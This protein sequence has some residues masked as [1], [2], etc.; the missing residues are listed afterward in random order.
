VNEPRA[1]GREGADQ[2]AAGAEESAEQAREAEEAA[3]EAE[4]SAEEAQ[5]AATG[6]LG[7]RLTP[8]EQSE[9]FL[10]DSH[11]LVEEE[12]SFG[13]LGDPLPR[14][15][16]FFIGFFGA[17]GALLA[18]WLGEQILSI[19]S[20][21]IL[22]VVAMFLAVGLNPWVELIMRRGIKRPWAVL[23]VILVVL[24]VLTG[25]LFAIVPVFSDQV[26][27]IVDRAPGWFDQLQH[28]RRIQ[29]LDK[30]YD[31]ISR[32]QKMVESGGLAQKVFGGVVG[33]G[34]A[35]LSALAN[36]F[37]I[38]V[39]MLYFLASLPSIKRF[40]YRLAPASRR[41]RVTI[42]G[43]QILNN[44]GGYVSGA[45]IVALCAGLSTLV[46]LFVVGMGEYAV[47]L[48]VVVALLDVIP[49][50]GATL[51]ALVVVAIAFA[52]DPRTGLIA[53][54]FF[55]AYQQFEN[56]VIYP[57]VMQRSVD[58]PGSLIVIAALVG[59]SLL[60]VVGALLA[61]PTAAAIQLVLTEVVLKRQ[62]Q[63]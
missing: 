2:A 37:I 1:G 38:I 54:I 5:D 14:H 56:Y 57:R 12:E 3:R 40:G 59:A 28:N 58:I 29:E 20:I 46:F 51:G 8:H 7:G 36:A 55:V 35:L 44:V 10:L 21:L 27:T 41:P 9:D 49:M 23:I 4:R 39:L 43:D 34:V 62:D 13:T 11:P 48:A 6:V 61:I 19:G 47:A 25:F 50:I 42:L 32:V 15:S 33:V 45:F 26:G 30:K 24:A 31:V 60:G 53:L 17:V 22:I 18:V 16:P 63:R 52:T